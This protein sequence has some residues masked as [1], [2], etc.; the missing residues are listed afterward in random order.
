MIIES[1]ARGRAVVATDGG[2]IPDLVTHEVEGLLVPPGGLDGARGRARARARRPGARR[3]DGGGGEGA[4]RRL[5][6]DSRTSSPVRCGRSSRQRSPERLAD[7]RLVFVTQTVD[8]DHPVLAQTVDLVRA[9]ARALRGGHGPL[10]LGAPARPAR[11]RPASG[12]SARRT[13]LVR[14]VFGSC[15]PPR[16]RCC[17]GARDPTP[18]SCTWCR[19]SCC[20]RRRSTKLLRVPRPPLVHALARRPVAAAGDCRS[21]TSSSASAAARSR[22]RRRSCTRPATRSTSR[23]SRRR[24]MPPAEGPLRL[25]ALGRTAR[26]KGYDTMLARARAGDRAGARRA[27]RAPW[28]PA[29][30]GRGGAPA[31]AGGESSPRPMSCATGFGSSLRSRGTRS[32]RCCERPMRS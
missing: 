26:W 23:A 19:S 14:G 30:R 2:G 10:R 5:A 9:L 32:R 7:V 12:P 3:A 6:L 27:A 21:W 1:F 8:A 20:W 22:S 13:R 16:P 24:R 15:A 18:S 17:R 25:L 11:Q 4:L 31:R 28:A 29:D